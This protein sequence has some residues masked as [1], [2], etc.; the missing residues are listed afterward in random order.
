MVLAIL[1]TAVLG[2]LVLFQLALAF[3]APWGRF[4]WG[5]QHTGVLPT[6]YRIG[7]A[8]SVLVY[9]V[10]ALLAF[11]RVGVL[12]LVPDAVSRVGMWIVFG[13]LAAG[14]VMNAISRS[15]H[16]RVT[17]TPVALVLALLAFLIAVS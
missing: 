7:S 1:F 9:V 14:V 11:D 6:G 13:L 16:E 10:I 8:V 5:G 2:L 17:A 4:A 12:Q 3:G 15:K